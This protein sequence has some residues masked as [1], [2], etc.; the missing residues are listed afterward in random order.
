VALQ[1]EKEFRRELLAM[2]KML[3]KEILEPS[4]EMEAICKL[5]EQHVVGFTRI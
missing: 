3:K 4:V 1:V 5:L 2:N